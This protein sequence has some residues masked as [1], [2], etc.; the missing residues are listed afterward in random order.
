MDKKQQRNPT[1]ADRACWSLVAAL[2]CLPVGC[3]VPEQATTP[4]DYSEYLKLT[5][6]QNCE[7][8]HR[9]CGTLC[10]AQL[11][12]SFYKNVSRT[13]DYIARGLIQ[14]DK[15]AATDC[16]ISQSARLSNCDA[17]VLTVPLNRCD[18]VLI[19]K[20]PVGSVCESGVNSCAPD[21]V[22]LQSR[23]YQRARLAE[24]CQLS[25]SIGC[26]PGLFCSPAT[27]TTPIQCTAY[28]PAGKSCTA[29]ARCDPTS[30]NVCLPSLLCGAPLPNGASCNLD[31]QCASTYCEPTQASCA[32]LPVP[33][34]VRQQLCA[35]PEPSPPQ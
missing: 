24:N 1:R 5:Y 29:P 32:A 16:L 26:V 28:S 20:A 25:G 3:G 6:Q 27:A 35:Q 18:K 4:N 9:C 31:S 14:F 12:T 17:D 19:P 22:C 30:G 33:I 34:S 11:D 8:R 7:A 21:T 13:M 15:Q 23:C 2:L 10:S